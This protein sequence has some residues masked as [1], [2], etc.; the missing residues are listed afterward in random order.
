MK[1]LLTGANGI[2]GIELLKSLANKK[3][4]VLATGR[5]QFR[6]TNIVINNL[7]SYSEVELSNH[8]LLEKSILSF[9]PSHIIHLGAI[10]QVDDCEHNKEFCYSINTASSDLIFNI[11]KK[12]GAKV[13]YLSTDFVFDGESGPYEEGDFTS[14]I[15]YY[16]FTK[17]SS[18]NLLMESGV[19][20]CII[21][22]V[23]L[24]GKVAASNRSNFIHWVKENLENKKPIK[25]V[26]DQ[27]RTPTYIPD[28]VKGIILALESNA[29][30]IYHLAGGETFTPYE[31]ALEVATYLN[32]DLS[33]IT[34]VNASNFSQPAKRPL[35]TGFNITKAIK[36]LRYKPTPFREALVEIFDH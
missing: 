22:T 12:I 17:M 15:N 36:N 3:V 8:E 10:T 23:L 33:L 14:P 6:H 20:Y 5:G 1:I 30:G 28:L 21:R 29:S 26:N 4:A 9:Q 31:M 7:V 34:P 19:D 24:Y 16:G 25:V 11:A 35:K 2:L 27:V 13:F 32:L 18:E